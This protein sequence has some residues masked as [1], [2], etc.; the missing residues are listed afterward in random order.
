MPVYNFKKKVK[1][2]VV[3]DGL[4]YQIE[5]NPDVSF[6]QTFNEEQRKVKTLHDPKNMF[7]RA[8]I[9]NAS[10]ANFNFT[11]SVVRLC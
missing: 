10:P 8:S 7:D 1:F 4:R 3:I 6:S 11:E 5:I 2:F 9:T